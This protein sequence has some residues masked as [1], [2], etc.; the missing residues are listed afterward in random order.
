MLTNGCI[1]EVGTYEELLNHAGPFAEFL[2]AYLTNDKEESD[3]DPEG[4]GI[5][6]PCTDFFC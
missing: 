4:R 3:E 2:T 5:L 6:V 1:T